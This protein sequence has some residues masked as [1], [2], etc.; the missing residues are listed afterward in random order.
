MKEERK[1]QLYQLMNG[2]DLLAWWFMVGDVLVLVYFCAY[3]SRDM[4]NRIGLHLGENG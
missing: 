2:D 1:S 4:H 3:C